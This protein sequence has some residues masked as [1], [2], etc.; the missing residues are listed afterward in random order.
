MYLKTLTD[1]LLPIEY[2]NFRVK[3]KTTKKLTC[4]PYPWLIQEPVPGFAKHTCKANIQ[5]K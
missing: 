2:N 1:N 5:Y 4:L 3:K